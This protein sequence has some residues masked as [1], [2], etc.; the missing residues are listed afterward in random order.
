MKTKNVPMR[1]CVGCY[2]SKPKSELVRIASY[3]GKVSVDL[4][5][6]AN[7]RGIYICRDE[8]CLKKAIKKKAVYRA[9]GK[10]PDETEMEKLM[11]EIKIDE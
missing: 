1:R 5:G 10:E 4:T 6:K 11:E 9:F 7:G 2:T 3:E 8:K